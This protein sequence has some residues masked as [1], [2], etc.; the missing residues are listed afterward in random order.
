MFEDMRHVKMHFKSDFVA[1]SKA[2]R[3]GRYRFSSNKGIVSFEK[4]ENWI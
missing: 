3:P 4:T 1:Y 2:S